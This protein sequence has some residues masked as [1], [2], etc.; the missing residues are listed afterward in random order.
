MVRSGRGW[1]GTALLT[2]VLIIGCATAPTK[3]TLKIPSGETLL[4]ATLYMAGGAGPH[5][6]LVWFHGFPGLA[7][8]TD[9]TVDILRG[10]GFNVLYPHYRGA[11]AASGTY[12]PAHALEDAAAILAFLRTSAD[13]TT[14][15]IDRGSIIPVGDSFGSWIAL[16]TAAA[17]PLVPCVA[18][19]LV[20]NLG[21][22]GEAFAASS[23]LR[24]VFL[25]M[26]SEIERDAALGYR[27][28]GGAE[29][30]MEEITKAR[31][32]YDL[33][34]VAAALQNR[35]VLL[36][37][38]EADELAPVS[39]HLDPV[40]AVIDTTGGANLT[41]TILPGGHELADAAYARLLAEW[42]GSHCRPIVR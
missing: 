32:R 12:S 10:A 16:K 5:P 25:Q 34:D 6:T 23:E 20:V 40:A 17:D 39:I 31:T 3:L 8:P 27:F 41:R 38:A 2:T 35:P 33:V 7:E 9:E 13:A 15:G 11:F 21:R 1:R 42:A 14:Y 22:M 36:I 24:G 18:G 28:A 26:F 19:A 4:P 37:G 30:L 29:G